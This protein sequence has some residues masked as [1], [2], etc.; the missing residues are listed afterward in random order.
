MTVIPLTEITLFALGNITAAA[1]AFSDDRSSGWEQHIGPQY[2]F[3][4]LD[5]LADHIVDALHE[6]FR[7]FFAALDLF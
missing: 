2:R 7:E 5:Q 1:W 4:G 6:G 3:I